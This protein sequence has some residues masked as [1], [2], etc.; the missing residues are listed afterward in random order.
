MKKKASVLFIILLMNYFFGLIS[1][2]PSE[3]VIQTAI[4]G[5]QAVESRIIKQTEEVLSKATQDALNIKKTQ[6][7]I[8]TETETAKELSISQTQTSIAKSEYRSPKSPHRCTPG[9]TYTDAKGDVENGDI[10]YLDILK[11]DSLLVNNQLTVVF[12]LRG[13]PEK[14][15]INQNGIKQG[16]ADY[17]WEVGVDVDNNT[18]TGGMNQ[19]KIMGIDYKLAL[20]HYVKGEPQTGPIEKLIS[21]N[22]FIC[23]NK[24][25]KSAPIFDF[26]FS[27]D[28]R[29]N[30][31]SLTGILPGINKSSILY[32]VTFHLKPPN[33]QYK[34]RLCY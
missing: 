1:C 16:F 2:T 9:G 28:Y 24:S 3:S 27:I 12:Y 8:L 6:E 31:I 5:T 22:I 4:A 34:D 23:D 32:F 10:D 19:D 18:K 25:C 14:I 33:F 29:N 7:F 17:F 13:L 30:S 21:S 26:N 20:M 11:V 15:T